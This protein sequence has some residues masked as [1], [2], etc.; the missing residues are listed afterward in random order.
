[1]RWT[2]T[3]G[4]GCKPRELNAGGGAGLV[5]H[6]QLV[7][8]MARTVVKTGRRYEKPFSTRTMTGAHFGVNG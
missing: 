2:E 3:P 4:F 8:Y 1:L 6:S 7:E 5:R